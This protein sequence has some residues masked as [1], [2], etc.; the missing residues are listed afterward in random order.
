M[1]AFKSRLVQPIVT[2]R[3]AVTCGM[4]LMR[5]L[6][7]LVHERGLHVQTHISESVDEVEL[8]RRTHDGL[9]Y[10]QV[11]D[12]AGLL[13]ARTILAHAVHLTDDE[14]RMLSETGCSVAHCPNSNTNLRSGLCDVRRLMAAGVVVGL[15]T[16]VSGGCRA[17][18]LT[19]LKDA[20][21]VSLH[22]AAFKRQ[23]IC[24]SGRLAGRPSG[25]EV[26]AYVPLSYREGFYLATLGGAQALSVDGTVGN[27]V[28]GKEFDALLVDVAAGA[29]DVWPSTPLEVGKSAEQRLLEL[30]QRFVYVGDDRNIVQVFVQGRHVN[31]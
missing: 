31:V 23:H 15:G 8:V 25:A 2:P 12:A 6:G 22:L 30:V 9:S 7:A 14:L 10:A 20:L 21:D 17:S 28:R 29:V 4:P 27:F 1:L 5:A 19:A 3:F 26:A 13:T 11:Y 16:D 18:V 24:G